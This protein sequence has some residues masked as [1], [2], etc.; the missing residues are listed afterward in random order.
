MFCYNQIALNNS[1]KTSGVFHFEFLNIFISYGTGNR[2]ILAKEIE[3]LIFEVSIEFMIMTFPSIINILFSAKEILL[4]GIGGKG[5]WT[6][7]MLIICF[8]F[9]ITTRKIDNRLYLL[10]C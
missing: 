1:K 2:V 6:R 5:E 10:V 9:S 8:H 3:I 7:N 4:I